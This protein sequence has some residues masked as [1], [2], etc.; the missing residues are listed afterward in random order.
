MMSFLLANNDATP[1]D[2]RYQHAGTHRPGNNNV[3]AEWL[4][5]DAAGVACRR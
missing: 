3:R 1:R 4:A 5:R 2:A